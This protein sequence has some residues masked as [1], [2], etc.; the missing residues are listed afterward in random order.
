M[1]VWGYS[2]QAILATFSPGKDM[3]MKDDCVL[4]VMGVSLTVTLFTSA[5]GQ[6]S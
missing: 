3:Y 4:S 6:A 2:A 1:Y 5:E